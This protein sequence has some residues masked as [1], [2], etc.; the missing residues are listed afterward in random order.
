MRLTLA[1]LALLILL[2]GTG[3]PVSAQSPAAQDTG[4]PTAAA[5]EDPGTEARFLINL[6]DAALATL[7]EQVSEITGRTLVLDPSVTGTVTVIA[8]QPLDR[9]AVW[10]L[11]Q[12][13]LASNGYAALQSGAFWRVVPQGVVREGGG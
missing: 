1:G 13:V 6:R 8:A 12:S 9:D 2:P 7:A 11:F 5:T 10:E 3:L 4:V